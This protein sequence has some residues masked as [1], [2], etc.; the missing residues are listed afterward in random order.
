MI[1]GPIPLY[2]IEA[3]IAGTGKGLLSRVLLRPSNSYRMIPETRREDEQ[4]KQI[5]AVCVNSWPAVV[6]DN[7]SNVVNS[8]L[9]ASIVT[10]KHPELRMMGGYSMVKVRRVPIF[11]IT[12]NNP[13]FSEENARRVARIRIVSPV[14]QPGEREGFKHT[15]LETWLEEVRADLCR[16][17][18]TMVRHWLKKG[19]PR[20]VGRPWGSFE[21]WA[22]VMAGITAFLGYEGFGTARIEKEA[23]DSSES[24]WRE[25][26]EKWGDQ[27]GDQPMKTGDLVII[28]DGIDGFFTE[29][30][31]KISAVRVIGNG[32]KFRRGR[33][34]GAWKIQVST[35]ESGYS[36]WEL[37]KF[38]N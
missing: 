7:V 12:A 33:I 1:D 21:A 37:S 24:R 32:L 36:R 4:E 19:A 2:N 6:I 29:R 9:L 17:A 31:K 25:L 23:V 26:V 16:A 18:V 27:Y 3:P 14:E 11:V 35:K 5:T 13:S 15:H 22:D 30:E 34:F 20:V 28:A 8:P 10:S 38:T